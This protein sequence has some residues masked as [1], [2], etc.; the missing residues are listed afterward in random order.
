MIS[1]IIGSVVNLALVLIFAFL[2]F[3]IFLILFAFIASSFV[4]ALLLLKLSKENILPPT[5]DKKLQK[6]SS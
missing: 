3:S 2:N 1:I 6:K 5:L 4:S